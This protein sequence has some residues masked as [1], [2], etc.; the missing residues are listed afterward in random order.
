MAAETTSVHS[1]LD[2]DGTA[3][4]SGAFTAIRG[5]GAPATCLFAAA[6][7]A[8]CAGVVLTGHT[9][10]ECAS[11][12]AE[13]VEPCLT[14][15]ALCAAACVACAAVRG[16]ARAPEAKWTAA[17]ATLLCASAVLLGGGQCAE[18]AGRGAGAAGGAVHHLPDVLVGLHTH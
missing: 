18:D 5:V 4:D 15:A 13:L 8:G 12:A 7:W 10:V 17:M 3:T 1:N 11:S 9:A 14:L 2:R 16:R 6:L